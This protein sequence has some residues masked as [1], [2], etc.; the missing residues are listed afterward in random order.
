MMCPQRDDKRALNDGDSRFYDRQ[1]LC[2]EGR[3]C[4]AFAFR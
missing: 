4:V 2:V 1:R 3:G